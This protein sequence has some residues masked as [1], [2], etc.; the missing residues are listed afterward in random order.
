M[1]RMNVNCIK[2]L[3]DRGSE[4]SRLGGHVVSCTY[5]Q[6][7]ISWFGECII[8][9]HSCR[10]ITLDHTNKHYSRAQKERVLESPSPIFKQNEISLVVMDEGGR[11]NCNKNGFSKMHFGTV[12]RTTLEGKLWAFKLNVAILKFKVGSPYDWLRQ[13]RTTFVTR[14][15]FQDPEKLNI[16]IGQFFKMPRN[17]FCASLRVTKIGRNVFPLL[18]A[19]SHNR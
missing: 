6:L 11:R 2:T 14:T 12:P 9:C 15:F 1:H 4:V 3:I 17:E 7:F 16:C 8:T 10:H 13:V 5:L 18:D 19:V